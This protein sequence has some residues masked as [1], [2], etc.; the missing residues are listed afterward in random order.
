MSEN[1][2]TIIMQIHG[3]LSDAQKEVI[4]KDDNDA[5]PLL[6]IYYQKRKVRVARKVLVDEKTMGIDL[7]KKSSWHDDEAHYFEDVVNNDRFD[8]EIIASKGRLEINKGK[9]NKKRKENIFANLAYGKSLK[10]K[11]K[12]IATHGAFGKNSQRHL[13]LYF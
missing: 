13:R 4:G 1:D 12:W 5:P 2:R 8:L 11:S 10:L 7:L 9:N 6:K 3:R